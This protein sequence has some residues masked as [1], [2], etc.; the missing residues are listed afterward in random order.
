M[1]H[2]TR[3]PVLT[4]IGGKANGFGRRREYGNISG[5]TSEAADAEG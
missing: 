3:G 4:G 1:S 5:D 2:S